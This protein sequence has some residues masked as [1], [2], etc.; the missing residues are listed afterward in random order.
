M[1]LA[2]YMDHH[3][4]SE[5]TNGLRRRGVD[6]ITAFE[7]AHQRA[8]DPILLGRATHLNRVLFSQDRDLLVHAADWQR[9][10]RRFSGLI[11][12]HQLA[13]TIGQCIDGL[14]LLA[15]LGEPDELESQVIHL[16][17]R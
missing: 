16:P 5:I 2:L 17:F 14:E 15:V 9:H 4:R 12:A 1:S 11:Y 3:V 10:Q 13:L 8:A 7:D 6:V